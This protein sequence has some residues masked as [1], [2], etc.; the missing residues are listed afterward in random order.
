MKCKSGQK[1][2]GKTCVS[3]KDYKLLGGASDEAKIIKLALIGAVASVGGWAI[4]K[5]VIGITHL[6]NLNN[7]LMLLIG[8]LIIIGVYKLGWDKIKN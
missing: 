5:S 7:W 3:K 2:V 8:F 1:K 6:E 4:F